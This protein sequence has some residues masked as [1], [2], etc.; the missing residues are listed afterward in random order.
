MSAIVEN[1]TTINKDAFLKIFFWEK[2]YLY[3][4]ICKR[5]VPRRG[6]RACEKTRWRA[7]KISLDNN[8]EAPKND[9][10]QKNPRLGTDRR[11]GLLHVLL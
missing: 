10:S 3:T 6:V 5:N 1:A 2:K 11:T 9:S 7:G 8:T 4:Y